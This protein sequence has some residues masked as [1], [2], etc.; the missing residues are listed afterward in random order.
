LN[1]IFRG[2][3]RSVTENRFPIENLPIDFLLISHV[4]SDYLILEI[5]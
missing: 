5:T 2:K 1:K 3:L 4:E